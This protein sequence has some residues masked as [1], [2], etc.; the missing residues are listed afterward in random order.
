MTERHL[1]V[2]VGNTAIKYCL[3]SDLR[4]EN[5]LTMLHGEGD[6]ET[7]LQKLHEIRELSALSLSSVYRS[8]FSAQLENW[9]NNHQVAFYQAKSESQL[10]GIKNGYTAFQQLGVDRLLAMV[11]MREQRKKAF[12]IVSCG[13]AVTFDAVD[14]Y[15]QHLG[16]AIMPGM[17]LL[18]QSLDQNTIA[19]EVNELLLQSKSKLAVDTPAAIAT[20][21]M[22]AIT[23]FIKNMVEM[24]NMEM[25]Q[26]VLTGGYA[27][28][29]AN[30][31]EGEVT[32]SLNL[33]LKGLSLCSGREAE[34]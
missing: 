21:T 22:A 15:G 33:V 13:T 23:G 19:L 25:N 30:A 31:L 18:Q 8:D 7:E 17:G 20:G 11:A 9:C 27:P 5:V 6:F 32:I 14:R 28:L 3:Q 4:K 29:I 24:S 2:D 26:G 10:C 1:L 16:G 34:A 12:F